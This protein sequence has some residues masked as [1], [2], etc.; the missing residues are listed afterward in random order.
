M[1]AF[2]LV[3]GLLGASAHAAPLLSYDLED[4]DGGFLGSGETDQWAWGVVSNGPGAG[5]D[6]M[7]AWSTG[8][9]RN[10]L[11]DSVDYL[12]IPVPDLGSVARPTISFRHWYD[13]GLGDRAW[14][15]VDFGN[16]FVPATPLYGYPAINGYSG[17]SGGWRKVV[18]DL[19]GFGD[20]PRVRLA[21][22]ADLVAVG[23]GWTIDSVSFDDGDVAAP[24]LTD[25]TVLADTES[26]ET[27][28]V[29]E[30][31]AEDDT[32]VQAVTL[33]WIAAGVQGSAQMTATGGGAW[34][35]EIPA[36]LPDTDVRYWVEA[37]DG[38][39]TSREPVASGNAFRVYLPAP[40]GLVGPIGRVVGPTVPI[41]WA[42][43]ASEHAVLGYEVL[44]GGL[45]VLEVVEPRGDVP[46]LGGLQTFTVR[47]LYAEGHGDL[48]GPLE[49]DGVLPRVGAL[50]PDVAWPGEAVRVRLSGR[51]L[52]L[53]EEDVSL[54]LGAGVQI[55]HIDVRD[56][57]TAFV[58]LIVDE[59]ATAGPR[60]LTLRSGGTT[61]TLGGAFEVLP[62]VERPRL[63]GIE[64]D[65]VRQGDDAELDLAYVGILA[66]APEVD[67]G[68]GITVESVEQVDLD[69]LRVRYSVASNAPLGERA[70]SVDDGVR[71]F[72]GVSL[73]VEDAH[74]QTSRGC[75]TPLAP[76]AALVLLGLASAVGR[77]RRS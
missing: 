25:L 58:D 42:P 74:A 20:T 63:T 35:A 73:V 67:L 52:L 57:D 70:V 64:P 39:N 27:P 10:Y 5:F 48:S 29:V 21:F 15:E 13:I 46:V 31:A 71:L 4:D 75:G 45:P 50:Q 30:V 36:Q 16:G 17:A 33:G 77:R 40:G 60:A 8:L 47:A 2:L 26:L 11:N 41:S 6:G 7:R 55:G 56:V 38:L 51:Y 61:V 66:E 34:R 54:D 3:V 44:R 24:R 22:E 18:V 53:V 14:I 72:E 12:E 37:T 68:V 69:T 62:D 59:D 65:A 43:P 9:T 49:L 28:Y 19:T 1:I 32:V 23:P 76:S